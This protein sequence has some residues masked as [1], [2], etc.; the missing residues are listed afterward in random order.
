MVYECLY[1][2][3]IFY[4]L[5][6][7]CMLS[8]RARGEAATLELSPIPWLSKICMEGQFPISPIRNLTS[9]VKSSAQMSSPQWDSQPLLQKSH[10]SD[11][12]LFWERYFHACCLVLVNYVFNSSASLV[13]VSFRKP[14]LWGQWRMDGLPVTCLYGAWNNEP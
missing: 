3:G 7:L 4:L 6:N 12:G 5:E 10:V 11:M 1:P 9:K 13:V 2:T 14:T 8:T